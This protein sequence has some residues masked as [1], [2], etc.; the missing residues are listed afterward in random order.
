MYFVATA[1]P[2][3]CSCFTSPPAGNSLRNAHYKEGSSAYACMY[4]DPDC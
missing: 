4:L 1:E 2:V 3:L